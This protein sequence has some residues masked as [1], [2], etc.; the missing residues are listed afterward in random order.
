MIRF[1][2]LL[3]AIA[4]GG[5]PAQAGER[6]VLNSPSDTVHLRAGSADLFAYLAQGSYL[7]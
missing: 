7:R 4:V 5:L 6:A 3:M 2:L 1:L